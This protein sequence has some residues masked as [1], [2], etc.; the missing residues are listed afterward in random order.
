VTFTVVA[1]VQPN[2]NVALQSIH[3]DFGDGQ[4]VELGATPGSVSHAYSA[5]GTFTASVAVTNTEGSTGK[6]TLVVFVNAAPRPV[7]SIGLTSNA[8]NP[9]SVGTVITFTV[10]ASIPGSPA[11]V[12][13]QGI[14]LDFGDGQSADLGAS[15]T[16]GGIVHA[17]AAAGTYTPSATVTDTNGTQARAFLTIVV[18]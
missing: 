2:A 6:T 3:L 18:R 4:S 14:R 9:T 5:V 17:Y 7:P 8:G 10:T 13:I 1:S 16:A 11:N 12:F 15:P